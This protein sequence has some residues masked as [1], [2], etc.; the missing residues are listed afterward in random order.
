MDKPIIKDTK[1]IFFQSTGTICYYNS[2]PCTHMLNSQFDIDE[3]NLT[4]IL[5]YKMYFFNR[6]L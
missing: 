2:S 6:G 1:I 3:I 5:G 4:K